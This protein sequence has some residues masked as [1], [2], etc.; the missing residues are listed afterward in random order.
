MNELIDENECPICYEKIHF[1]S[2]KKILV[3]ICNHKICQ[4]CKFKLFGT[5]NEISCPKCRKKLR[6]TDFKFK[7]TEDLMFEKDL[8]IRAD[9]LSKIGRKVNEFKSIR[10][11][12]DYLEFIEDIIDDLVNENKTENAISRMNNYKAKIYKERESEVTIKQDFSNN[13]L[14][15]RKLPNVIK[16]FKNNNLENCFHPSGID[17]NDWIKR[18]IDE[19]KF[20]F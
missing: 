5:K 19:L 9:V 10:E 3:S 7:T 11:Y 15:N 4:T 13:G 14:K 12:D 6:K 1:T 18:G 20:Y 8:K 2:E 16:I 17:K